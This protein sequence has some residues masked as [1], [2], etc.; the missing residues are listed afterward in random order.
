MSTSTRS[1][2][3]LLMSTL[4]LLSMASAAGCFATSSEL[5]KERRLRLA[6]ERRVKSSERQIFNLRGEEVHLRGRVVEGAKSRSRQLRGELEGQR[7]ELARLQAELRRCK[8]APPLAPREPRRPTVTP[9]S[10]PSRHDARLRQRRSPRGR[11]AKERQICRVGSR[12]HRARSRHV[13]RPC[14]PGLFCCASGGAPGG[15]SIC[16][17]RCERRPSVRRPVRSR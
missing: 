8:G 2:T 10:P 6:A 13:A 5:A 14:A 17:P 11:F 16:L 7:R 3:R 4:A 15:D 9:P 12:R 1:A